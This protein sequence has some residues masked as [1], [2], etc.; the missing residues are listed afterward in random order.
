MASFLFAILYRRCAH[1]LYTEKK[2]TDVPWRV[3]TDL[4]T[5]AARH[6]LNK[7]VQTCHGASQQKTIKQSTKIS[8]L[9]TNENA[10]TNTHNNL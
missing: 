4:C 1:R 7:N 8:Y 2:C 6:I 9:C 10:L 5:D 3:Y